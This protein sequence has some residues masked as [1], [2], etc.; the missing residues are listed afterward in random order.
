MA[1]WVMFILYKSTHLFLIRG[2]GG[3]GFEA[4]NNNYDGAVSTPSS[5]VR[6]RF[7]Q[8]LDFPTLNGKSKKIK[9]AL[10]VTIRSDILEIC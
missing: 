8:M 4:T 1:Q 6:K 7:T 5:R 2:I 3:I 10:E 9:N